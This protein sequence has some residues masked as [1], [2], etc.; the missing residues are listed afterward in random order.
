MI[1]KKSIRMATSE[2]IVT[3]PITH[4]L[5]AA[6][7]AIAVTVTIYNNISN[8]VQRF[9]ERRITK[10]RRLAGLVKGNKRESELLEMIVAEEVFRVAYGVS[11]SKSKRET[12]RKYVAEGVTSFEILTLAHPYY[13]IEGERICMDVWW[14]ERLLHNAILCVSLS[15]VAGGVAGFVLATISGHS[16]LGLLLPSIFLVAMGTGCLY[17]NRDWIAANRLKKEIG[18]YDKRGKS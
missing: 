18:E 2:T 15:M 1:E 4:W 6:A 13:R 7:S 14:L 5:V 12:I 17:M 9:R 8:L 3:S 16:A 11:L 10:Y